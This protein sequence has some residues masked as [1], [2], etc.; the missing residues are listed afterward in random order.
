M[1]CSI[2]ARKD[3]H[4]RVCRHRR[5]TGILKCGVV[6]ADGRIVREAKILS[7]PDALIA[8]FGAH[9][10]AMERMSTPKIWP[11][12][13]VNF[14]EDDVSS[15]PINFRSARTERP[16]RLAELDIETTTLKTA[17]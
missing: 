17:V 10:V 3:D 13:I 4:E 12:W 1:A 8:W 14:E 6:D 15:K 16:F 2:A 7:E 9:G 11:Y 5:I